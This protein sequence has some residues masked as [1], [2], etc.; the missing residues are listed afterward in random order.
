MATLTEVSTLFTD[1]NDP[2]GSIDFTGLSDLVVY[3]QQGEFFLVTAAEA[4]GR[5]HIF[6]LNT[7]PAPSLLNTLDPAQSTGTDTVG[8]I[9]S[10]ELA[11]Q[12][13]ILASGRYEDHAAL[14]QIGGNQFGVPTEIS[15]DAFIFGSTFKEKF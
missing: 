14:T 3:E 8:H 6:D 12:E 15:G 2:S 5:L 7:G 10:F 4:T 1:I 9:N 13:F 11:G